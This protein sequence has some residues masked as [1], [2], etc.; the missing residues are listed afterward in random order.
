VKKKGSAAIFVHNSL[1]F[2]NI[3]I[4]KLCE[5]QDIEI[6][7]LELSFGVWGHPHNS[8][9]PSSL[10]NAPTGWLQPVLRASKRPFFQAKAMPTEVLTVCWPFLRLIAK[11]GSIT[12]ILTQTG[13][14]AYANDFEVRLRA[15]TDLDRV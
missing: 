5:E 2:S 14:Y 11:L 13:E 10:S 3:F 9:F 1:C 6:C 4:V 7:V 8:A 12:D 15:L